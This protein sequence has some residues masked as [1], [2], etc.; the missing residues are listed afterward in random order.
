ML[1]LDTYCAPNKTFRTGCYAN[2]PVPSPNLCRNNRCQLQ[3]QQVQ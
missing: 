1:L 3:Q 2:T